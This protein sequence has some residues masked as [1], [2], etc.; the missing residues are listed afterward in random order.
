MDIRALAT[1]PVLPG[2]GITSGAIV[3]TWL[4]LVGL[5]V[6]SLLIGLTLAFAEYSDAHSSG[7]ATHAIVQP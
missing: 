6:V 3:R 2:T 5:V 7:G 1:D 4:K